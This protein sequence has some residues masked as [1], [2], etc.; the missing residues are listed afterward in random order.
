[1]VV[2]TMIMTVLVMM[3]A[4]IIITTFP[5]ITIMTLLWKK[6]LKGQAGYY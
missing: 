2:P 4:I 5:V 1:M 3:I 6:N